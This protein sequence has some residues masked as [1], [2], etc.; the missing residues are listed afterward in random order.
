MSSRARN[1]AV[2]AITAVVALCGVVVVLRAATAPAQ[3]QQ[4]EPGGGRIAFAGTAHRSIGVV[5]D[6]LPDQPATSVPVADGPAH[7]EDHVSARGDLVVFTSLRDERRPQVYLRGPDG[8]V[9]RLTSGRDAGHPQLS[10]DLRSVVFDSAEDGQRDL[11]VVGVDGTGVRRLTDS[12]GNESWPSFSPDGAQVAFATDRDGEPEVYRQPVAGGAVVRVTDEPVGAA[13]EPAWNPVDGRIAYTLT[14]AGEPRLR[15]LDGAGVGVPVL[16]GDQAGWRGHWPVWKPDGDGLLFLSYDQT[17][18]CPADPNVEKVYQVGTRTGLPVPVAPGLL[19]AED[20]R[21]SSP[22]WSVVGRPTLLV[23]RTTAAVRNAATLQDVRPDGADPRD[24]GVE[25]LREDPGVDEDPNR[26]FRPRAGYDPW[27]QRQSYSPDGRRIVVTRFEDVDGVRAQRLWLVDADG[28]DPRRL[29]VADRRPADWEFDPAWSPDGRFLAF[30]RRSPGG[31]R[32]GPGGPGRVV[33]VD[34]ATGAVVGRLTPPPEVAERED[35]QPAWSPDGTTL[36]FTRGVVFNR[37]NGEEV[38][39]NHVWT[40]RAGS[41]DAQRDLSAAVCGFDCEV[42]DDSAAFRPDSGALVF[43][44][45]F[46]G[47]VEVSR[48]GDGCRVV[49]PPGGR[50]CSTPVT[51]PPSGPFQPRDAA[52][53]PGGDRLVLTTR[54]EGPAAAPEELAVLDGSGG[55]DRITRDLPGRQKEPSWQPSVDLAVQAPPAVPDV[56]TGATTT[57]AVTVTN[58]GPGTSPGTVLTAAVPEGVRVDVVRPDRGSCDASGPRCELGALENGAVVRVSVELVGVVAGRRR[59]TWSVAGDVLDVRPGDNATGTDIPVRDR[60]TAPPTSSTPPPQPPPAPPPPPPAP[61]A[62]G[63]GVA[64]VV[65]PDPSY[66]GGRATASYTVRNGGG[67]LA[68]GL[69]LD[70]ALPQGVPVSALPPGCSAAGCALPDL[71]PGGSLVVQVVFAPDAPLVTSVGGVLRTSGTDAD[72][73]DNSATAPMRVLL[74][75]IVAVPPIGE[76]GFVTSVRGLDFPP[77]VPVRL[78]W[79]PGITAAA[80][81]TFPRPDGGFAAQLLILPKDATGPRTITA[82]G[83]GFRPATTPFLVV[84]GTIGPPDMVGRR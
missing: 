14:A 56:E 21:V 54:R 15:V 76:P 60:T 47:L 67:A 72:P 38:R 8:S 77:G 64:V 19:L 1:R 12:P 45:E 65:Q 28:G 33:V 43:N 29:P 18:S 59:V 7:F 48:P 79:S 10:P 61:P 24:L 11:W 13:G 75:R 34:A 41:L 5:D 40:A 22:A 70:F 68:T 27:T 52:Y 2:A 32:P 36:A 80:A 51:A 66:V 16:G 83:P 23:S 69:R 53:A 71:A 30:A 3:A 81:P 50:P 42:T 84:A 17:C 6:P 63:P 82:T 20:R 46:D 9:R 26:L 39:D 35:T 73:G 57:V 4:A 44:R 49:L 78:T 37:P 31:L 74:P 62:A 55:L 58:R 25:V